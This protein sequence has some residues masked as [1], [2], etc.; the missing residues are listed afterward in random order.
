MKV[1][2]KIKRQASRVKLPAFAIM[3]VVM[4]SIFLTLPLVALQKV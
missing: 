3:N 2:F 1:N 4:Q